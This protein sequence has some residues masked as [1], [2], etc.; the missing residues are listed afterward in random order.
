MTPM[1]WI[2][3]PFVAFAVAALTLF[4]G[5]GLGTLLMP[6][7]ALVFPLPI[8]VAAT[9]VVH[10]ANNLFK[11]GL[12]GRYADASAVVRFG[13]PAAVA[14]FAGALALAAMD[15]VQPIAH[16][17]MRG[18]SCDVTVAGIVIGIVIIA[19][20]IF[21]LIPRFAKLSFD[22]K[23]LPVGGALSGFFGGLSGNQGALRAAFLI[24]SGLSK[25]GFIGTGV[26]CAIIVDLAR[27]LVYGA[28][29]WNA[30]FAALPSE[31]WQLVGISTGA[32]FVGSYV[33]AKLVK[34]VTL[35][36]LQLVVGLMLVVIG[37]A[38]VAGLV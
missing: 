35:H 16:W 23:Y 12:V 28:A 20:S 10:L 27:L 18:H 2:V 25:E 32:A 29:F 19:F 4:S 3:I 38:L 5:F 33:G 11:L 15:G 31:A 1:E 24:K 13:I 21:D 17:T 22:R 14:S 7:F 36:S 34:K 30:K 37:I 9:A 26:V 8:A 6:A